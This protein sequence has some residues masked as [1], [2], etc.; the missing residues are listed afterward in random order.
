[1]SRRVTKGGA[2]DFRGEPTCSTHKRGKTLSASNQRA[3]KGF[4]TTYQV[5]RPIG[6]VGKNKLDCIFVKPAS[7]TKPDDRAGSYRFAPHFGCTLDDLNESIEDRISDHAPILVDL[8]LIEPR[9]V[10][11][12][13][14]RRKGVAMRR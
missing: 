12:K 8:P 4:V 11:G 9:L 2:F 14:E 3:W 7:L 1:L 5:D 13:A 10:D 6:F